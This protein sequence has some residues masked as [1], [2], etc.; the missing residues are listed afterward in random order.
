MY[1]ADLFL[2]EHV[3]RT[4]LDS[5]RQRELDTGVARTVCPLD[6]VPSGS[7]AAGINEVSIQGQHDGAG[8]C[9]CAY[10]ITGCNM[11]SADSSAPSRMSLVTVKQTSL[12]VLTVRA[13]KAFY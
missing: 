4:K 8:H 5:S 11:W 9:R 3:S 6:Q 13:S 2:C 7:T 1:P 10:A 12:A